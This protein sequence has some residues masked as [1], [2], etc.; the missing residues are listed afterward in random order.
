M[1]YCHPCQRHL[2]GALSCSGCGASAEE[3]RTHADALAARDD[4]AVDEREDAFED[5][6]PE[7]PGGGRRARSRSQGRGRGVRVGRRDR[8]AAA[9]RRRRRR[10]LMVGAGLLLAAGGLSLA[11]LGMEAPPTEPRAAV[12]D[13]ASD[14]SP[15]ASADDPEKAERGSG[16][17][18][19]ADKD[20]KK[21]DKS[22][23]P[24][25]SESEKSDTE[26][27]AEDTDKPKDRSESHATASPAPSAQDPTSDPEDTDT[28]TAGPTED[29]PAPEPSPS[30]TCKQFLWWCS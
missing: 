23:S 10:V 5:D 19:E 22:A 8:K 13:D 24:S 21:P 29:E 9:H 27:D 7:T 3:C 30:A 12:V 28:P 18:T 17:P 16:D 1:D 11:E 20:G 6:T 2:N 4:T 15:T 26:D 25:A 14:A